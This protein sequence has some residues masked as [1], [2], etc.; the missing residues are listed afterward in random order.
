MKEILEQSILPYNL[1]FTFGLALFAIYWLL[2]L[3]GTID[4]DALDID[5]SA[6]ADADMETDVS[7]GSAG[8]FGSFL[9]MVNA[10]DI[11]LMMVLSVLNLFMWMFAI[12]SNVAFNPSQSWLIAA[13]LLVVNFIV[14]CVCT[15]IVTQPLKPLVKAFKKGENDDEP[16]IG[17]VGIVKSRIIDSNYGQVEVPRVSGAPAIVNC[18]LSDDEE[19]L[20]RG[21][22]VLVF[23]KDKEK[24]LF[25]V[26]KAE[27]DFLIK[28]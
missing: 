7:A 20:T 21:S 28:N 22:E 3:L 26:R 12:I 25:L 10:T 13:G 17:R 23:D 24:N 18:R 19:P 27:S 14:S 15:K 4:I 16:V 1:P 11:P 5:F 9:K 2:A 6:D 8:L